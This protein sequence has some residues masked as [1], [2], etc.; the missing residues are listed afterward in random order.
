MRMGS[1]H[2]WRFPYCYTDFTILA[3]VL[4]YAQCRHEGGGTSGGGSGEDAVRAAR[5]RRDATAA[6]DRRCGAL[7]VLLLR[8]WYCRSMVSVSAP[9]RMRC[10]P[11]RAVAG[12]VFVSHLF[13]VCAVYSAHSF[14]H[15]RKR[16]N[17]ALACAS[18]FLL[19]RSLSCSERAR[20]L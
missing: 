20:L 1:A 11:A 12:A 18:Y 13:A 9:I 2:M 17:V 15:L 3:R 14:H 16:L 7:A 6:R 5:M 19:A 4:R 10:R 8:L